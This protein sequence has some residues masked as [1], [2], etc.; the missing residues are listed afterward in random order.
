MMTINLSEHKSP[1]NGGRMSVDKAVHYPAS[2][3]I[4]LGNV[5]LKISDI[6]TESLNPETEEISEGSDY[7]VYYT[8]NIQNNSDAEAKY[9][10]DGFG[11]VSSVDYTYVSYTAEE[12]VDYSQT[13]IQP[14]GEYSFNFRVKTDEP[15]SEVGFLIPEELSPEGDLNFVAFE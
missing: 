10:E 1:A 12:N 9:V 3:T 2:E 7:N 14:G 15:L 13:L 8:L 6:R 4:Y 5:Q 11:T